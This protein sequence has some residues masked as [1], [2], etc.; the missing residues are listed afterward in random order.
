MLQ[1]SEIRKLKLQVNNKKPFCSTCKDVIDIPFCRC[2]PINKFSLNDKGITTWEEIQVLLARRSWDTKNSFPIRWWW[3]AGFLLRYLELN[4][5]LIKL[6]GLNPKLQRFSLHLRL[7]ILVAEKPHDANIHQK[8]T[9][10]LPAVHHPLS[11]HSPQFLKL[12][13]YFQRTSGILPAC[14][15]IQNKPLSNEL[16]RMSNG[17]NSGVP[18]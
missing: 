4:Q 7:S 10:H 15:K 9:S 12:K 8:Q 5:Q 3:R 16:E 13:H 11:I 2:W 6:N 18:K 17:Q 14:R 1:F